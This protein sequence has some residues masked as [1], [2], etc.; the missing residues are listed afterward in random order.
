MRLDPF[1]FLGELIQQY[2]SAWYINNR[3][4]IDA[5]N[6]LLKKK[7]TDFVID[8]LQSAMQN[9]E[10]S[11]VMETPIITKDN[12]RHLSVFKGRVATEED[13]NNGDAVFFIN[14]EQ[15]EVNIVDIALP[16]CGIYI[17][18]N[19]EQ[20]PV[21]IVQAEQVGNYQILGSYT[22]D[23][24]K[25]VCNLNDITFVEPEILFE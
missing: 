25:I 13:F 1:H 3:I 4:M 20:I 12:W 11:D 15:A 16:Q 6:D 17:N 9:E 10:H 22:L 18:E 7:V 19:N 2:G 8:A 14:H 24:R 23:G 5:D 21:I